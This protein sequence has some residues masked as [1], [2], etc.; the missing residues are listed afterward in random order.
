MFSSFNKCPFNTSIV[1]TL[2]FNFLFSPFNNNN[3]Y[4]IV[5]HCVVVLF[6][7]LQKV[8]C[9]GNF[10]LDCYNLYQISF[11]KICFNLL[12]P[13]T[14]NLTID[15]T[16]IVH[17]FKKNVESLLVR[18]VWPCRDLTLLNLVNPRRSSPTYATIVTTR[19]TT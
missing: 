9:F 17:I 19:T 2:H 18:T 11:F 15:H 4:D 1:Q 7:S 10:S 13:S 16:F 5:W 6:F 14:L 8:F 3:T 12:P